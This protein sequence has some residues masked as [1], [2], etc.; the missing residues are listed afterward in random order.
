[1][2]D[3]D[4]KGYYK[5]LQDQHLSIF[6][7]A[8][9]SFDKAI[10]ALST[11][12]LGFIFAFLEIRKVGVEYKCV[13]AFSWLFLIITILSILVTFIFVQ[14]HALHRVDYFSHKVLES[15]K[16]VVLEHWT[17]CYIE[18]FQYVSAS[19]F[20]IGLVLFTVFVSLNV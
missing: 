14:K 12:S 2:S 7:I 3:Q 5:N 8:A 1:M 9:Q 4:L 15:K 11:I 10:L 6:F 17:D 20:V 18:M 19:S 13:L 16:D